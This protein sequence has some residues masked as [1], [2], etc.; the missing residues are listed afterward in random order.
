M[1]TRAKPTLKDWIVPIRGFMGFCHILIN[2]EEK[3]AVIID[4][5]LF[6]ELGFIKYAL[7]RHG[8]LPSSVKAILLTHGHLDH[9]GNLSLLKKYTN[10][11]IYAHKE[12][13]DIIDGNFNYRGINKWCGRLEHIGRKLLGSGKPTMIDIHIKDKDHLPYFGGIEVVHL[14]GHTLGHCGFYLESHN[15]FFTGD[16]FASY[17]LLSHYPAPILN[18]MPDL[19]HESISKAMEVNAQC[20]IP[21]H[22]DF[23]S[24]EI[25]RI[26]MLKLYRKM[27]KREDTEIISEQ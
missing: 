24:P 16:L 1:T 22:Y 4:T 13:Q 15:T 2:K 18:T 7:R 19:L 17:P 14:P 8:I 20:I 12:E 21:Q 9:S 25:H 26:R 3:T 11:P 6:G 5:G 23:F 27:V 10:A